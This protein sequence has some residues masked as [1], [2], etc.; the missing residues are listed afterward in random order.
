LLNGINSAHPQLNTEVAGGEFEKSSPPA[1]FNKKPNPVNH[2]N[3]TNNNSGRNSPMMSQNNMNGLGGSRTASPF[4][5]AANGEL[6]AGQTQK[7]RN[8]SFFEGLGAA[9]AGR[10][11]D[12]APSQGEWRK[13]H[14]GKSERRAQTDWDMRFWR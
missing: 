2:N 4:S 7:S 5:G 8:E 1:N 9:N 14:F 6:G 11:D 3:N 13:I 10:R 12:I